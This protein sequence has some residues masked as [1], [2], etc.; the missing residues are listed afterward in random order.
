LNGSNYYTPEL[1]TSEEEWNDLN[2]VPTT[3]SIPT[4]YYIRGFNEIGL[5]PTPKSNVTGGMIVSHEPQHILLTQDDFTQASTPAGTVTVNN[6]N[7][8]ITHSAAAFTQQMVGRWLQITDG[9]DGK[10]YKVAAFVSASVLNL[11]N[12]YEGLSGSGKSFRIG[13]VMKIP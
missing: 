2:S 9:T 4:H 5:Y 13:E 8:A 1:I 6:G 10:W 11:E 7:V 12:Y 3:S